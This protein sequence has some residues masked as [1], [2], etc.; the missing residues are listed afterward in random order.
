ML[1]LQCLCITIGWMKCL[2]SNFLKYYTACFICKH[3]GNVVLCKQKETNA[4][5][6]W[7]S[8]A[9]LDEL[10]FQLEMYSSWQCPPCHFILLCIM[11]DDDSSILSRAHLLLSHFSLLAMILL[12]SR[13]LSMH[14]KCVGVFVSLWFPSVERSRGKADKLLM[15]SSHHFQRLHSIR[16][17]CTCADTV[18]EYT[19]MHR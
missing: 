7:S 19:Q 4:P 11:R 5:C 1:R 14:C 12:I 6:I 16:T 3:S 2:Y 18:Y 13:S 8:S 15:A 10:N 17:Y 9:S